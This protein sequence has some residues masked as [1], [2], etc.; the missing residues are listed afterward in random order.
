[1]LMCSHATFAQLAVDL[2]LEEVIGTATTIIQNKII[3][4]MDALKPSELHVGDSDAMKRVAKV[5]QAMIDFG[6]R[7]DESLP[8]AL[9]P[10]L[11]EWQVLLGCDEASP[12]ALSELVE[13]M[14]MSC[15]GAI[16]MCRQRWC[17]HRQWLPCRN[18]WLNQ[19]SGKSCSRCPL[20]ARR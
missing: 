13:H 4:H 10:A 20:R 8:K 9:L 3:Q 14:I 19:T 11:I 18:T 2:S 5:V 7:D 17:E 15:T 1:M 6:T 12:S 16:A